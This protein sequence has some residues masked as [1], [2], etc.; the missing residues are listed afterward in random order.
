[1]EG[2]VFKARDLAALTSGVGSDISFNSDNGFNRSFAASLVKFNGPEKISVI[3][4]GQSGHLHFT[5]QINPAV[6]PAGAVKK[7]KLGMIVEMDKIF[8][9]YFLVSQG[10]NDL[11]C[12]IES[13]NDVAGNLF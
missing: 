8:H 2:G 1:M 6:D 4:Y 10:L 11:D 5:G 12:L 13:A 9:G 3:G 7:R